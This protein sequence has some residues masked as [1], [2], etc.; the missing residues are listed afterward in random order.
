[1]DEVTTNASDISCNKKW[2]NQSG[3]YKLSDFFHVKTNLQERQHKNITEVRKTK[4]VYW[5]LAWIEEGA[6]SV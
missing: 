1:M 3:G 4:K 2:R 6:I 5:D